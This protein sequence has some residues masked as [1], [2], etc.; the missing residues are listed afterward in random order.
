MVTTIEQAIRPLILTSSLLG[1]GVY[2]SKKPYLSIFYSLTIWITYGCL[3]YYIVTILKADTFFRTVEA[4]IDVQFGTLTSI[5]CVIVNIYL[6]KRFQIFIK[7]LIAVDNT[8]EE[9]GTPKLYRDLHMRTKGLL[10]GWLICCHVGNISD[11][12]CWFYISKGKNHGY[13]IIIL[14]YIT[15]YHYLVNMFVD[16][17]FVIIL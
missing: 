10:I 2:S 15:N 17:L 12:I 14:T 9:L 5:T 6:N 8:L 16:L 7:R 1:L 11:I 13:L 3:F 4:I